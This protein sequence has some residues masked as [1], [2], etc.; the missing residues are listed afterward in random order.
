VTDLARQQAIRLTNTLLAAAGGLVLSAALMFGSAQGYVVIPILWLALAQVF[1][2]SVNIA[3]ILIIRSGYNLRFEDPALSVPQMYW[4]TTCAILAIPISTHLDLV[5]YLMVLITVVF[6]IFRAS[7]RQFNVLCAYVILGILAMHGLRELVIPGSFTWDTW[8]QW[9]VFSFCAVTLTRLCQALVKLRNRLREQNQELKEA[10]QAKNYF[11][12]NMSHEIRTPMNGV[13]GMLDIALNADLPD[14]AR[15][16]LGIA[17]SSANAL[18]IIIND[19]LDFSKMEAG[20]LRIEPVAFDLEHLVNDV[21]AAFSAKAEA[22]KLELILDIAPDTPL[23]VKADPVRLRQV[24]NNLVANA[25]KFTEQGEIVVAVEPRRLDGRLE[26]LWSVKD[27]GIGIAKEKQHELFASFTQADASTTRLYG[28]TGLGLAICKQLC[29]LMGGSIG[30]ESEPGRGSRFFFTLPAETAEAE[31]ARTLD[32]YD[33]NLLTGKRVLVVDDNATNRLV[34]RK[35]L[36]HQGASVVEAEDAASALAH[37]EEDPAISI[38]LLDMQMPKVDGV[39]LAQQIRT[40]W[41]GREMIMVLLSSSLQEIEIGMLRSLGISA[42]LYKPVPPQRLLR[43]LVLALGNRGKLVQ[44]GLLDIASDQPAVSDAIA[45]ISLPVQKVNQEARLLLVEDNSV[46]RDVAGV[47]LETLGYE[48]HV[49][50][51]GQEAVIEVMR[52]WQ[53]R[54][55][56]KLILMDCQMPVL[57][58]Y[59]ATRRIRQWEAH[60]SL[61]PVIIIAM[62]ANAMAG[63][64]EKCLE[65]GMNDYMSKPVQLEAL[66]SKLNQWLRPAGEV[67]REEVKPALRPAETLV[68]EPGA[69]LKLVRQ[70]EDRM[71]QLLQ[72][73]L[74]GLDTVEREIV[75]ALHRGDLPFAGRQIHGLKGSSANL[76]ARALPAFLADLEAK[77]ATGESLNLDEAVH[78]LQS[79]LIRLRGA[80]QSYL[81]VS[82]LPPA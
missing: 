66:Q 37:L 7:E 21:V 76:G 64:R 12:A 62:T 14:D 32:P 72:S 73:F 78:T 2:W 1:F 65:A 36:E 60:H 39:M 54:Q 33:P 71:V 69:L 59:E 81:D 67:R 24:L 29:Q 3:F 20:K 13:L 63:D 52:A 15:R 4:A 51:D 55:P 43:A 74:S 46:N 44:T 27:S 10:L 75:Q 9:L 8:M 16:Y 11:L 82:Y 41:P 34:L 18:L 49:A 40:R 80:M 23:H 26:L 58:G 6:G 50:F 77:L 53:E 28:G 35:Q 38:T 68:W 42:S 5:L 31:V 70:K 25:L 30:V 61:E 19:I 79:N 47:A 48:T 57:D 45:R 22:K 17:Q 56:Y